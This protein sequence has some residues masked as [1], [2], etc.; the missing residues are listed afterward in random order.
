LIS[1]PKASL[2]AT[3]LLVTLLIQ[4]LSAWSLMAI[5]VLV[6][7]LALTEPGGPRLSATGLGLYLVCG[8]LGAVVGSL[9]A[10]PLVT[11]LGA[12][13]LSQWALLVGALGLALAAWVPSAVMLAAFIIGL[14]YGPIT[15]AS[16]HILINTTP[17]ERRNLVF[18]V[19]QTGVPAGVALSGF[20]MPRL[21]DLGSW[22]GALSVVSV[23][24]VAVAL[25][26]QTVQKALDSHADEGITSHPSKSTG[27]A[28][29]ASF[30]APFSLIFS[31]PALR[32][33]AA[34][35][36][37]L[38]GIQIAFTSYIVT[39]LTGSLA[40]AAVLAGS[41]LALSQIGGMVGRV[42]WG[43]ISDKALNAAT[44]LALLAGMI[45]SCAL[46]SALFAAQVLT[47]ADRWIL[48]VLMFMFGATASGWNG[49]Y[50]AEVARRAPA[51]MAAS[52]T[53]GTLACT[54]LGV[55]VGAPVFGWVVSHSGGFQAAFTMQ[56]GVSLAVM[57]LLLV[58][59]KSFR[60]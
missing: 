36:F 30:L 18:S 22:G 4:A 40:L 31:V 57:T 20:F 8:Y 46:V 39:F 12:I 38:S 50:L 52:A 2:G 45:A 13:R 3:P 37:L 21:G 54:F 16:S 23:A 34:V 53:S 17:V 51:G 9:S 56:T 10:G 49:V 58:N 5:P 48:A 29:L 24:C 47:G 6:P 41:L 43:Y 44:M 1:L 15:P 28:G 59:R 25:L 14:G 32:V 27:R 55:L 19:K 35:S 33:L 26:S 7:V 42:L 60:L 11:R